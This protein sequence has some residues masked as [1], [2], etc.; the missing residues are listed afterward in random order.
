MLWP[1]NSITGKKFFHSG[2]STNTGYVQLIKSF[3]MHFRPSDYSGVLDIEIT[4][5]LYAL[6]EKYK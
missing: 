6:I 3:Q 5:I 1:Y 4:A 2:S